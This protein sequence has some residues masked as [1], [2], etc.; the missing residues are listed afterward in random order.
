MKAPTFIL[1]D[2]LAK[3]QLALV[4]GDLASAQ[5]KA[6]Q[7]AASSGRPVLLYSVTHLATYYPP[8]LSAPS[9]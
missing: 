8:A 5:A 4:T 6:E 1:S 2:K 9:P 7:I 3:T